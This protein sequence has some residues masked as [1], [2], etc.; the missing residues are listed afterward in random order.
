MFVEVNGSVVKMS[1]NAVKKLYE[2]VIEAEKVG[3]CSTV[4]L[5]AK[6]SSISFEVEINRPKI[7][8]LTIYKG[9]T[10]NLSNNMKMI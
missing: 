3:A 4:C 5:S 2:T 10:Q 9:G 6:C 7:P 1:S 8:K